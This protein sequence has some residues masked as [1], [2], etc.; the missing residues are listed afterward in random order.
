MRL[1]FFEA[2]ASSLLP[3]SAEEIQSWIDFIRFSSRLATRDVSVTPSAKVASWWVNNEHMIQFRSIPCPFDIFPAL[4]TGENRNSSDLL[5]TN[6]LRIANNAAFVLSDTSA[7]VLLGPYVPYSYPLEAEFNWVLSEI[8]LLTD[9]AV[10]IVAAIMSM[11]SCCTTNELKTALEIA[12]AGLSS[13]K[14]A[15]LAYMLQLIDQTLAS[16]P[17][18]LSATNA[19]SALFWLFSSDIAPSIPVLLT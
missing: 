14:I 2:E 3:S 7:T 1:L 17:D 6:L 4:I 11:P 13:S 8:A 9:R 16:P 15:N 12:L 19:Q 5:T 18:Q 10:S